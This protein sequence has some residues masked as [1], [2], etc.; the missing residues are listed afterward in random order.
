MN[1]T[2]SVSERSAAQ[3]LYE[4]GFDVTLRSPVGTRGAGGTSDLLVNGV[5][6]DVYTPTTGNVNAIV[7]AAAR[8]GSQVPGGGVIIDLSNTTVTPAQL[9]NIQARVAGTGSR[10]GT[11]VVMPK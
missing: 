5:P 8:K 4:Q 9:A 6:W 7:S 1:G 2:F 11:V 3:H 10:V